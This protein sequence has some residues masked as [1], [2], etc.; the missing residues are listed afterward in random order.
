MGTLG[1]LLLFA[2]KC[3]LVGPAVWIGES[4]LQMMVEGRG[5]DEMLKGKNG[6]E[7]RGGGEGRGESRTQ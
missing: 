4:C 6:K 1:F 7:T 2:L 5:V 3:P